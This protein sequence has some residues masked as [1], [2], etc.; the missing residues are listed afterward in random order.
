[1]TRAEALRA[2]LRTL[3]EDPAAAAALLRELAPLSVATIGTGIWTE[4]EAALEVYGGCGCTEVQFGM[5]HYAHQLRHAALEAIEHVGTGELQQLDGTT[6]TVM[7][8]RGAGHPE[9]RL[10]ELATHH[11]W[12][13]FASQ[14]L[15]APGVSRVSTGSYAELAE[16]ADP[17]TDDIQ[18]WSDRT[19]YRPRF[20]DGEQLTLLRLAD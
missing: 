19:V 7:V 16:G 8:V 20:D 11:G 14:Q 6:A 5:D 9:D 15:R 4:A 3:D 1:M 17:F 13:P 10:R 18:M 2:A 12:R